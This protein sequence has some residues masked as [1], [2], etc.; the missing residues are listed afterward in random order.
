MIAFTLSLYGGILLGVVI[1][2]LGYI[3]PILAIRHARKGEKYTP[4]LLLVAPLI[5]VGM[6]CIHLTEMPR[7]MWFSSDAGFTVVIFV[8]PFL[9]CG[10]GVVMVARNLKKKSHPSPVRK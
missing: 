9:L 7:D 10:A 1:L 2:S 6:H 3:L 5:F 4:A 8:L